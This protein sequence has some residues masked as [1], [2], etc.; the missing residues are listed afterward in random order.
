M[1][2]PGV[3]QNARAPL[4]PTTTIPS[5]LMALAP[6]PGWPTSSP[7]PCIPVAALH[8]KACLP[9][10]ESLEPATYTPSGVV[11]SAK[12]EEPPPRTPSD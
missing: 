11:H 7:M 8:R 12:D 6:A 10:L 3:Q 5:A 9:S 1:P 2:P 4:E